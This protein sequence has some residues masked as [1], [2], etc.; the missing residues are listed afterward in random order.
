[1]VVPFW[2]ELVHTPVFSERVRKRL[3]ANNLD[4]KMLCTENGRVR[5]RMK[6][7]DGFLEERAGTNTEIA[8]VAEGM[9]EAQV[10]AGPPWRAGARGRWLGIMPEH[11]MFVSVG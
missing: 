11:S 1:M 4:R 8:E 5:K 2:E 7:K 3:K 10:R 9:E 6:R